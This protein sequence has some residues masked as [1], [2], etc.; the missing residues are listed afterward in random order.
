MQDLIIVER[1]EDARLVHVEQR[2]I[3]RRRPCREGGPRHAECAHLGAGEHPS[4]RHLLHQIVQAGV[5]L[6][7]EIGIV[8]AGGDVV[9]RWPRGDVALPVLRRV[10]L[11]RWVSRR[12]V[13]PCNGPVGLS[14]LTATTSMPRLGE[15]RR[16]QLLLPLPLLCGATVVEA[17]AS[18][19]LRIGFLRHCGTHR[20]SLIGRERQAVGEPPGS[21]ATTLYLDLPRPLDV[22]SDASTTPARLNGGDRVL[23]LLRSLEAGD[24]FIV[25]RR[26]LLRLCLPLLRLLEAGDEYIVLCRFLLRLCL[27]LLLLLRL[28]EAGDEFIVLRRLL[29]R[30]CLPLLLRLLLLLLLR[31]L[32]A[33]DEFIVLRRLLLRLCLLLLLLLRLRLLLRR[34]LLLRSLEAGDKRVILRRLL[35]RLCL[36]LLLL[37]LRSLEAG[38]E[39]IVLRRFL[40]RLC[41][42][43][44]LQRLLRL[45][46]RLRS[47]EAGDERVI[48]R[49]LLLR[50][51]PLLLLVLRSLEA[52]DEFIVLRRLLLR[53]L[54]LVLRS[55]VAGDERVVLRRLLDTPPGLTAAHTSLDC[56]CR[57]I[58]RA[59]RWTIVWSAI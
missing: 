56:C 18:S 52:G 45:R 27:S 19:A 12:A 50:L 3:N 2:V 10:A 47:L 26:F 35:L 34:L 1:L 7:A 30:L 49:R 17:S 42:L 48:L 55:L 13:Y 31:L 25:L 8:K 53:G 29:L 6:G 46:L 11:G 58:M 44:L 33:G 22:S 20:F 37:L 23:L 57:A 14:K 15:A 28:L 59:D 39:F 24:E 5:E 43:L 21:R 9:I 16:P 40:L 41:L 36:P 32:E 38:D 51:C 4:L 54:L